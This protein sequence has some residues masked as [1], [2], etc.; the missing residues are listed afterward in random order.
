LSHPEFRFVSPR[1]PLPSVVFIEDATF[2]PEGFS[3]LHGV[4]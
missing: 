2:A 3:R 1:T 4:M